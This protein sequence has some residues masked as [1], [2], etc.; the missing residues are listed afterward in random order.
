MLD[1]LDYRLVHENAK[2]PERANSTDAGLDLFTTRYELFTEHAR[3][4]VDT[5]VQVRIPEGYVGLLTA[6]SSLQKKG[7]MLANGVGIIDAAYRGNLKVAL[8]AFKLLE[9]SGSTSLDAGEK[10][11][12]LVIVPCSLLTPWKSS[13]SDE[14]WN[15]TDR[16]TGGFGSTGT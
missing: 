16:G 15:N 10:F 11:A 8:Y 5:G 1:Y 4:L 12:Q 13:E 6:R 3:R 14:E 9:G 7:L 2:A